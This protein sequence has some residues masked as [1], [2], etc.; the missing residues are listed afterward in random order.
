MEMGMLFGALQ[1]SDFCTKAEP[2]LSLIGTFITIFRWA[3]PVLLI[4]IGSI[5]IGRAMV[6]QKPDEIKKSYTG[7]LKRVVAGLIIFFLPPLI[8]L[9]INAVD[10]T[11]AGN[12]AG[13]SGCTQA[14]GLGM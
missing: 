6:A 13:L 11:G 14:L 1:T 12:D 4:I 9:V 7:L 2:V 3:I 10:T 8:G 5:D